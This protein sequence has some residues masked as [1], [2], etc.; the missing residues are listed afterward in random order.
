MD[1]NFYSAYHLSRAVLPAMIKNGKG[2]LFNICSIAA[3]QAYEGGG[4]YSIS[5]FAMDALSKN[6][7]FELKDKQV[8]VT[9]VYPGAVLTDSWAGFDNSS[10]R[11]MEAE[12]IAT[13]VLAASR[14]SIQ[15]VVEE[16]VLRPQLGDL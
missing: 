8:K 2:H 5:K 11:I 14:L 9:T 10:K 4:G 12:D 16:I 6:L 7:R 1:T 3:L 13:M 15:A